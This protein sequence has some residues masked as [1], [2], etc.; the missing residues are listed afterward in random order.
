MK[1][2]L[3]GGNIYGA[4]SPA[5]GWLDFSANIN[6][7]G[8]SEAVRQAVA[9]GISQIVHYPDPEGR[10]LK[11]ALA[12]HYGLRRE[13]LI[14]GNGAAE[15]LYVFCHAVRPRRVL[16]PVPSFSEYERAALA[17]G[18]EISYY[19]LALE[20]DFAFAVED[21]IAALPDHDCVILGNPNNPT[22]GLLSRGAMGRLAET[23]KKT[24]TTVVVDESFLDFCSEEGGYTVRDLVSRLDNLLVLRSLTKFYAIP[25]LRLGF[26]AA[27]PAL[28]KRL[29][30]SKDPWNVNLLAQKAG[31]AALG[32]HAYQRAA[33][34]F[35][36]QEKLW[37]A[38]ALAAIPGLTVFPPTVNF[39]LLRLAEPWPAAEE[40]CTAMR[41][42]GILLRDCSNYP[43]LDHR[44]IRAAV[45][46]REE[47]RRLIEAFQA[48]CPFEA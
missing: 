40:V 29:E 34:D 46:P 9:A 39:L 12:D 35:V 30:E 16:L 14:L 48:C 11:E 10:A 23:A 44:Y 4:D 45:R 27:H 26:A 1:R 28:V 37:L 31:V 42:R 20:H 13:E 24:S 41:Q 21:L 33:R 7:L 43:G 3:H 8:L 32:D 18:A 15:L 36:E 47:N 25:G 2:F 6:P 5:G 22:G 17:A 19:R 38:E